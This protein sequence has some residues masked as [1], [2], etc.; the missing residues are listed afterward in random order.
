MRKGNQYGVLSVNDMKE[1]FSIDA[2]I[3]DKDVYIETLV[4]TILSI[5]SKY[6]E[7]SGFKIQVAKTGNTNITLPFLYCDY[8]AISRDGNVLV[9]STLPRYSDML[10]DLD[11][12]SHC[13]D[14]QYYK[15]ILVMY[16]TFE[17]MYIQTYENEERF[18]VQLETI[19]R[20]RWN[21]MQLM[22]RGILVVGFKLSI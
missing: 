10:I 14:E 22:D 11:G 9:H 4:S 17:R 5:R 18:K 7:Y 12:N 15:C 2:I 8:V 19:E 3:Q 16:P 1:V 21:R 13:I 20:F 6:V